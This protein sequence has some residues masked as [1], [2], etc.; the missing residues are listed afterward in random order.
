MGKRFSNNRDDG[1]DDG[2]E[3]DSRSRARRTT[4]KS[5][6]GGGAAR[7]DSVV[8][9][10]TGAQPEGT[11]HQAP[12]ESPSLDV[13]P[14]PLPPAVAASKSVKRGPTS[15]LD[16]VLAERARKKKKKKKT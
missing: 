10:Q 2:D 11:E 4:T 13:S 16:E 9:V 15:Y 1:S 12:D 6:D 5:T 3:E 8:K 14:L 7:I